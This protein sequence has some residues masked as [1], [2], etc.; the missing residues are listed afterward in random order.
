MA[1]CNGPLQW[2][3]SI[4]PC[5]G[6][7]PCSDQVAQLHHL[8]STTSQPGIF[9]SPYALA[10]NTVPVIAGAP[11][12]EHLKHLKQVGVAAPVLA[13]KCRALSLRGSNAKGEGW[14]GSVSRGQHPLRGSDAEPHL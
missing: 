1:P 8:I 14:A 5:N 11:V 9:A 7:L 12:E 6:G 4:S 10:T 3:P 2:L 13:L